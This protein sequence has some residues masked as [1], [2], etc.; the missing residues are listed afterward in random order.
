MNL[1]KYLPHLLAGLTFL[2][3]ML[4]YFSPYMAGKSLAPRD[5]MEAA[6][7][8]NEVNKYAEK[9]E[10]I[11]WT[12]TSFSGMPMWVSSDLNIFRVVH[13][14]LNNLLP[15]PI[16]LMSLAFIGF[17]TLLS[18][19][20]VKP[21]LAFVGAMAYAL[22][23]FNMISILAGHA[24]KVFD[25]V[26]MAPL[27][28]GI[29]LVYKGKYL[30]GSILT[31][32]T[33]GMEIYY[34][35]IQINYYLLIM[36]LAVA[37]VE[38]VKAIKKDQFKSF[39]KAS[40]VL[41][42]A[43]L[44][45][46]S[47][48]IV[49]LWSLAEYAESST[50]GGSELTTKKNE[51][52][53]L[54]KDYAFSW[55]LGKME[56]ATLFI[57]YF[58]GGGSSEDLG[59]KSNSYNV[60]IKNGV[61]KQQAKG[62]V[63]HL[64]SYWGTQPFT[65]GP[66][67]V[68]GIIFYL[69]VLGLFLLRGGIKWWA[70]GLTI[71]SVVLAWGKNFEIVSDFFF[72]YVPLYNKFRSVTMILV[73]A[74]LTIPFLGTLVLSKIIS[75][76]FKK[77]DL[78]K[79]L[80][81][82]L[83]I[84]GGFALAMFLLGTTFFDFKGAQDANGGMPS[85]LVNALVEDRQHLFKMDALRSLSFVLLSAGFIW[86]YATDKLKLKW[87]YLSFAVMIVVDMWPVNKRYL[88][89]SSFVEKTQIKKQNFPISKAEKQLL[90]SDTSTYRVLSFLH[91]NPFNESKTSYYHKSIGGYS[92]IKLG[93]YQE[94][95]E[96]YISKN[97]MP[98]LNMLNTKYFF[99]PNKEGGEPAIQENPNAMGNA[100]F[101]NQVQIVPNADAELAALSNLRPNELAYV[102]ERFSEAIQANSGLE[103]SG[104]GILELKS[105]HPEKMV[106]YS[107]SNS[108]QFAVFSEIYYQ[109]GWNAYVDGVFAPHVRTDYVLRGM[110]LP[111]GKHEIIFK[112]EPNSYK[113]GEKIGLTA[114][115]ITVILALASIFFFLKNRKEKN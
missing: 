49:S 14:V 100:W 109:P 47:A 78:K 72:Y 21:W 39:M 8:L 22:S 5:L 79:G 76:K 53:G 105:Y 73:I 101:V 69:F 70:L 35:H 29:F 104:E 23:S 87:L 91:G 96:A 36:I 97:H 90:K 74:Q 27:L 62:Y 4:V 38:L 82:S 55:S 64:P 112:F 68:G 20:K 32:F 50:R 93:R 75:G 60:L 85:W 84:C 46:I 102:D 63:Q 42:G 106:Y 2:I 114:S 88:N 26:Y 24:N 33:L 54:D 56:T 58:Y 43:A 3:L 52:G 67:Y 40:V 89:D 10:S 65:V 94:L 59:E 18:V 6:G 44:I 41:I 86:A 31:V 80:L 9:G 113:I 25:M 12:N 37:I 48:N 95:I 77:E 66:V 98:V 15:L 17:Y 45:A 28:A 51:G 1:K 30:K 71:L 19:F 110:L 103:F 61:P 92:A 107:S 99:V 111:A 83:Y 115:I 7:A 11:E 81:N 108:K 13:K 16:L 34:N 57:P